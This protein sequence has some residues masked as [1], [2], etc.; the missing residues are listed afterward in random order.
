MRIG[1][2]GGTFN[3]FHSGHL[4][5]CQD[6]VSRFHLD[7]MILIPAAI[8]PH[9][10]GQG[11]A[12]PEDRLEMLRLATARFSDMVVSDIELTRPG[13]SY[14]VDTLIFYRHEFPDTDN[15]FLVVGLDAFLEFHTWKRWETILKTVA[16]LVME[17]PGD[18]GGEA[19]DKRLLFDA[20]I[21]KR[22]GYD[23]HL[24]DG[25]PSVYH[26]L[27]YHPVMLT[28]VD[29]PDISS[30]RIRQMIRD[31]QS[32]QSVAPESV[33]RYISEKGLYR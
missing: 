17:R 20:Y 23:L 21:R 32:I 15:L 1:L 8:P 19:I 28:P 6:V 13:P 16:I 11:L 7:R 3:P 33:A 26:H 22:F 2:F 5:A 30:S 31:C 10:S 25:Q 27:L 14:T 12:S 4:R 9:K 24:Q 18:Y 29:S